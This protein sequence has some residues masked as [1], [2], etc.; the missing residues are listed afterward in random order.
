M[1]TTLLAMRIIGN[2]GDVTRINATIF[3]VRAN[4]IIVNTDNIPF[5][6]W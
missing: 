2:A 4:A 1:I 6:A 5:I 3:K